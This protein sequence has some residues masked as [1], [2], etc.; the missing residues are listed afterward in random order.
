MLFVLVKVLFGC[1]RQEPALASLKGEKETNYWGGDQGHNNYNQV[2][3]E[4]RHLRAA[5]NGTSLTDRLDVKF[6]PL[7]AL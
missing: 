5:L 2:P 4:A 7:L 6:S 1:K 3:N